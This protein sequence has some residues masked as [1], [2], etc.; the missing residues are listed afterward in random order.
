[1]QHFRQMTKMFHWPKCLSKKKTWFERMQKSASTI[2]I[3][4][5]WLPCGKKPTNVL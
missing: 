2:I 3:E 4:C 1:M 5:L